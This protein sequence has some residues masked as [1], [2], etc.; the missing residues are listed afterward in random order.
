MQNGREKCRRGTGAHSLA[1]QA[2]I[3]RTLRIAERWRNTIKIYSPGQVHLRWPALMF[4]YY[5]SLSLN[6]H[7]NVRETICWRLPRADW[8]ERAG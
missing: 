6:L 7:A 2:L 5:G 4:R 8:E 1:R 3:A